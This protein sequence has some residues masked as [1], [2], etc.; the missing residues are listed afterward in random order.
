MKTLRLQE[1]GVTCLSSLLLA[2]VG[3]EA[4]LSD[5]LADVCFSIRHNRPL[6]DPVRTLLTPLSPSCLHSP[7]GA[8]E[9]SWWRDNFWIILAVAMIIVSVGL[10]LIMYCIFRCQLGQGNGHLTWAGG[11]RAEGIRTPE[12]RIIPLGPV[13]VKPRTKHHTFWVLDWGRG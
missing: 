11:G 12:D 5:S 1:G 2:R 6:P 8:M 3:L 10:G 4:G 7:Q 9:E 13:G